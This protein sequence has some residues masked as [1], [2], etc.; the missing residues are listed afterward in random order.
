MIKDE[1]ITLQQLLKQKKVTQKELGKCLG[2]TQSNIS[3]IC[4]GKQMPTLR[5]ALR[6]E[7]VL[8]IPVSYWKAKKNIS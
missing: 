6:L 2:V 3:R 1:D 5:Q 8:G 7:E 4:T